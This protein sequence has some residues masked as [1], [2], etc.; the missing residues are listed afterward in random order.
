MILFKSNP[1]SLNFVKP[2]KKLVV[3]ISLDLLK[4]R[5]GIVSVMF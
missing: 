5:D 3:N 4:N 2:Y 1:A